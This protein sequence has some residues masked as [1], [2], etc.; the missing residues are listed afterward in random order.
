MSG[1][2][3]HDRVALV[4]VDDPAIIEGIV[5]SNI[6]G[7]N[8][9]ERQAVLEEAQKVL[10]RVAE[11]N[12]PAA[13]VQRVC[14]HPA[15]IVALQKQITD[16]QTQQFLPPECDHSTFEQLLVTLRQELQVAWRTP[17][18][19]GTD[20]DLRQEPDDMTQDARQSVEEV[21]ALRTQL[22]NALSLA[23]RVA[24]T[25]PQQCED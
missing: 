8:F 6:L 10:T 20:E 4:S 7:I 14:D 18:T 9:G 2:E 23:A 15:Q 13:M 24:P 5:N 11:Y 25:P 3:Y 1:S 19:V 16:L 17:R 21:E 22:A 12:E